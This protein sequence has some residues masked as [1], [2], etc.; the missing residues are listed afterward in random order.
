LEEYV[1]VLHWRDVGGSRPVVSDGRDMVFSDTHF[2]QLQMVGVGVPG[3]GVEPQGGGPPRPPMS[4]R[5][6]D[7][8]DPL[9]ASTFRCSDHLSPSMDFQATGNEIVPFNF[10]AM[11]V[12]DDRL[13]YG[14]SC[15]LHLQ[16]LCSV[17][18]FFNSRC[19]VWVKLGLHHESHSSGRWYTS[20]P[21][22]RG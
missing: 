2:P 15:S 12:R 6:R 3:G 9:A 4:A 19:R 17:I 20:C 7:D 21:G 22:T 10:S 8:S 1:G 5:S 11:V 16:C 13:K 14:R 18:F